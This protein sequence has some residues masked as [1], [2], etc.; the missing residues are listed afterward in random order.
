MPVNA[1]GASEA[2]ESIQFKP[3]LKIQFEVVLICPLARH[4]GWGKARGK[5]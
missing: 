2:L 5:R 3:I 1:M 4:L